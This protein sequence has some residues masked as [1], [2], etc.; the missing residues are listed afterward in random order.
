MSLCSYLPNKVPENTDDFFDNFDTLQ[1]IS[2]KPGRPLE[3][4]VP[5]RRGLDVNLNN[6]FKKE[7]IDKLK[8]K[9]NPD[10]FESRKNN[11]ENIPD[12]SQSKM[13]FPPV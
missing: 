11:K 3:I 1:T 12:F 4:C 7:K 10:F 8:K 5:L 13:I 2:F 9:R 6:I